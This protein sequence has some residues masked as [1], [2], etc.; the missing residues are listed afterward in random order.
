MLFLVVIILLKA[1][2]TIFAHHK[3]EGLKCPKQYFTCYFYGSYTRSLKLRENI[4][5]PCLR[6]GADGVR[7]QEKASG[8]RPEKIAQ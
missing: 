2:I 3:R 7:T 8:R 5:R 6:T 4:G 1:Y